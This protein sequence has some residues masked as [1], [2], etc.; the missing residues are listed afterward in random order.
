MSKLHGLYPAAEPAAMAAP[1]PARESDG[2]DR[3]GGTVVAVDV[4]A[5]KTVI[6][7]YA[8]NGIEPFDRFLTP[9]TGEELS[10]SILRALDRTGLVGGRAEQVGNGGSGSEIISRIGI[11]APGPLD[12]EH[13][14][15]LDPP[16][17]PGWRNYPLV[18]T[19]ENQL[20]V[21]IK[22]E[23]DA[24]A[25]ALGEAVFGSGRDYPSVFYL[26][27]ST[28]IGA[29]LVI[30]GR[31]FGG[32]KGMAGEVHAIDPGTYFG[33]KTGENV[34]ERA[35]GPGMV[36]CAR[37]RIAAGMDTALD[38]ETL[39][40]YTLLT[41]LDADDPVAVETVE[42]ARNAI[43]GLLVNVLTIVA[44]SVIV[45]AGGL[46]TENRW[47]VDP[48]RD[49]VHRWITIPELREIPIERAA[50]WDTAVLYGAAVL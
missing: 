7:R 3:S 34:I 2:S 28:G 10:E 5:T 12:A 40:T 17:L 22:L 30:N 37:R 20:R 39:D 23:N 19:L 14:M 25:G 45:L 50:L 47:F 38:G 4:G 35:S 16:N 15:I 13:G 6:A 33:R 43:A 42:T 44:P 46:C 11:G 32:Y 9:A 48:V 29:G 26:T 24:N 36:R 41:A 27:I 1:G 8:D 31:I 21:P 49:R 18:E